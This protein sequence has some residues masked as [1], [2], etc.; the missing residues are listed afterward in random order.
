MEKCKY[1]S[2][3]ALLKYTLSIRKVWDLF[4]RGAGA[5]KRGPFYPKM[6]FFRI[7]SV[8]IY[9]KKCVTEKE[10]SNKYCKLHIGIFFKD[11]HWFSCLIYFRGHSIPPRKCNFW[12]KIVI[13][14]VFFSKITS[15][16]HILWK[17]VNHIVI[18]LF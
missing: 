18:Q 13:L 6:Y 4:F 3:V 2:D 17:N 12:S 8:A 7:F 1:S 15:N 9:K 14:D 5:R 16:N 10:T 11:S